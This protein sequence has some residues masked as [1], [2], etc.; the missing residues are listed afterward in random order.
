M[1][2]DLSGLDY[3]G[4]LSLSRTARAEGQRPLAVLAA[5]RAHELGPTPASYVALGRALRDIGRWGLARTCYRASLELDPSPVTNRFAYLA[6]A[7]ALR[8]TG[9][10]AD[11]G[12]AR[13][14]AGRVVSAN[15]GDVA[16]TDTLEAIERDL[17]RRGGSTTHRAGNISANDAGMDQSGDATPGFPS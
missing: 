6:L 3:I 7:A 9:H 11:L 8:G 1:T 16:A 13:L 4:A 12:T 10:P 15:P 5:H 2:R 17:R 14:L